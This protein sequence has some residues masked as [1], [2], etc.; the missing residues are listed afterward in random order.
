MRSRCAR[1]NRP[2]PTDGRMMPAVP[3]GSLPTALRAPVAPF[4]SGHCPWRRTKPTKASENGTNEATGD[5]CSGF[6]ASS[7]T[8]EHCETNDSQENSPNQPTKPGGALANEHN[9]IG[10]NAPNEPSGPAGNQCLPALIVRAKRCAMSEELSEGRLNCEA[11]RRFTRSLRTPRA[12]RQAGAM[13]TSG[14]TL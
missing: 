8:N 3:T 5:P 7:A 10:G 14:H 11:P 6:A 1:E 9:K 2:Q 13:F 4:G 12:R